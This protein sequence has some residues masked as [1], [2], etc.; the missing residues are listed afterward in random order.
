MCPG[1]ISTADR[2]AAATEACERTLALPE[3]LQVSAALGSYADPA[4]AFHLLSAVTANSSTEEFSCLRDLAPADPATNLVERTLLLLAVRHATPLVAEFPVSDSVKNLF[5]EDFEFYATPPARWIESFRADHVRYR[6]MARIVTLRR[7]PAGQFHWEMA[8]FPRS[9]A[10]RND[11]VF[12]LLSHLAFRMH[13]FGPL[14]ELHL[15]ER[16]KN[17]LMLLEA[18][19]CRSYY[20]MAESLE[21]QPGTKGLL[22]GSW[23]YC[24]ST[25]RITPHLAWL[26]QIPL[27]AGALAVSVGPASPDSGFL[28]GSNERRKL[29]EEGK[30]RPQVTCILWPRDS[31][32]A[33]AK[34][35]PEYAE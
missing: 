32:I 25:A 28:V 18:E 23:L 31:V 4:N 13:G 34:Q 12:Q 33:W 1:T 14:F 15:N 26:R 11:K 20:K 21:R 29:Y 16:R 10:L 2:L 27:D 5:A 19:G 7:F 17:R 8:A 9:W 30:Y 3:F 35:H 22:M 24:E 6:E